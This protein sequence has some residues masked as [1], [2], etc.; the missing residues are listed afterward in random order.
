[1]QCRNIRAIRFS[2]TIPSG[3]TPKYLI[4]LGFIGR[5]KHVA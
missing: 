5:R 4:S 1:M 2:R 3:K